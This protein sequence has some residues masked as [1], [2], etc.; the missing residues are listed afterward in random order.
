MCIRDRAIELVQRATPR[1]WIEGD[2]LLWSEVTPQVI[3]VYDMSAI[4]IRRVTIADG[5]SSAEVE[6]CIRDSSLT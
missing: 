2:K 4:L 3:S 1:L 5:V 6:M